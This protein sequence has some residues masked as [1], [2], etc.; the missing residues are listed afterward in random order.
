M[1]QHKGRLT[2]SEQLLSK[3]G[4]VVEAYLAVDASVKEVGAQ[5]LE[6]FKPSRRSRPGKAA[7]SPPLE[8]HPDI[9]AFEARTDALVGNLGN[10]VAFDIPKFSLK[11]K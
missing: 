3:F 10:L 9:S 6:T 5:P 1:K 7:V 4:R 8:E 11:N 2:A